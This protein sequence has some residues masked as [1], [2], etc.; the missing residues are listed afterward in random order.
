[1][2]YTFLHNGNYIPVMTFTVAFGAFSRPPNRLQGTSDNESVL[3][4]YYVLLIYWYYL[5]T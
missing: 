4:C 3:F 1:M 5:L 2:K